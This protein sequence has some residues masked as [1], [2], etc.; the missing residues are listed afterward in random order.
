MENR[1]QARQRQLLACLEREPSLRVGALAD[2]L[3]VT[4]ETVR[5]DLDELA[6]R[7]L[8]ERTYGG[9]L[10]RT[11]NE[12]V[13]NVRHNLLVEER[14][15]IARQ[16]VTRLANAQLILM[17]SGATTLHVARRMSVA[18]N[19]VT[20]ITHSFGV[21]TVLSLNPTIKV[22]ITPGRYHAG[23]GALYG[24]Q[25]MRYLSDYQADWAVLG[26]SGLTPKGASD[27]LLE[28]AEVY[29]A[30]ARQATRCMLV[31]DGSKFE[32]IFPARFTAWNDI[33]VLVSDRSPQHT[34]QQAMEAS[35]TELLLHD[36]A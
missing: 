15:A 33:D 32:R 26:A 8:L 30:M 2:S 16:A 27:A 36:A 11:G 23:E 24:A 3:R 25:T 17:G 4:A 14:T 7:G 19:H 10:L 13:L 34:L 21:A 28:M 5:R 1:K 22:Y 6:E 29:A 20:V 35:A 31:A 18:M 12:P 9:A